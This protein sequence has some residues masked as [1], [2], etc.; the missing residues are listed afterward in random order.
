M[1]KSK[2]GF[3]NIELYLVSREDVDTPKRDK[4]AEDFAVWKLNN[5]KQWWVKKNEILSFSVNG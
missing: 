3:Q 5:A 4:Q 1:G 2:K